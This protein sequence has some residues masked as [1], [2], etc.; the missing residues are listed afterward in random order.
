V[1]DTFQ[2]RGGMLYA[3]GENR[4]LTML[5]LRDILVPVD[6][7]PASYHALSHARELARTFGARLHLLHVLDDTV[8]LPAGTE[9]S[10][11][12]FPGMRQQIEEDARSRL[13]GL[14]TD[15]DRQ[16]DAHAIALV[17]SS[18]SAAI[19]GYATEIQ[20]DLIVMG[21]HGRTGTPLG[22]IG[23]VAEQVVR[24]AECPVLTMR[25]VAPRTR[26]ADASTMES[27]SPASATR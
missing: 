23:S 18:T 12:D 14:L 9:G 24:T 1:Q 8:A 16:A 20:A 7:E 2:I 10:V 15:E 4:R 22:V 27:R 13:N 17:A 21:T 6:F 11:S 19:V 5:V 25:P 26:V 3:T